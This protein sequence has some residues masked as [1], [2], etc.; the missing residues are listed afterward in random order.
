[1]LA[2]DL[3]M[4]MLNLS[5]SSSTEVNCGKITIEERTASLDLSLFV[6]QN[7]FLCWDSI[8]INWKNTGI[9][10]KTPLKKF[11]AQ[12]IADVS[13]LEYQGTLAPRII[14]HKLDRAR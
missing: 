10:N 11:I 13:F 4:K 3:V 5:T 12:F 9:F 7:Y 8:V 1:M 6:E 14:V 2:I